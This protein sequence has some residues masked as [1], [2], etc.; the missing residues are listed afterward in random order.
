MSEGNDYNQVHSS[1]QGTD[2]SWWNALTYI[3]MHVHIMYMHMHVHVRTYVHTFT[4]HPIATVAGPTGTGEAAISVGTVGIRVAV[5]STTCT[6]IN[7]CKYE[8]T[9][10]HNLVCT[11][12]RMYM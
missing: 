3:H 1:L 11:Y 9:N 6:L 4:V 7:V 2:L 5:V 10:V 8:W 12:T